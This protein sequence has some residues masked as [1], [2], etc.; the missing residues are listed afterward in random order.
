MR[1]VQAQSTCRV[2][3][4]LYIISSFSQ[5]GISFKHERSAVLGPDYQTTRR[6]REIRSSST[7]NQSKSTTN[8]T[9]NLPPPMILTHKETLHAIELPPLATFLTSLSIP[10]HFIKLNDILLRYRTPKSY[11]RMDVREISS[12]ELP[13][14]SPSPEPDAEVESTEENVERRKK[15]KVEK[16]EPVILDEGDTVEEYKA[17]RGTSIAVE[18]DTTKEVGDENVATRGVEGTIPNG[19]GSSTSQPIDTPLTSTVPDTRPRSPTPPTTVKP[20]SRT[21][22][23]P[24]THTLPPSGPTRR[25]RELRLDLRT[26]DAAALFALETWRRE[27]MRL[28]KLKMEHPD[29]IW[30]KDPTPTPTPE[31]EPSPEPVVGRRKA[32]RPR[33]GDRKSK[34]ESRTPAVDETEGVEVLDEDLEVE[35]EVDVEMGESAGEALR[36]GESEQAVEQE[37]VHDIEAFDNLVDGPGPSLAEAEST[38]TDPAPISAAATNAKTT[39]KEPT[40]PPS[41]DVIVVD[42]YNRHQDDSDF[43]PEP[44][45]EPVKRRG[46]GRKNATSPSGSAFQEVAAPTPMASSFQ[47]ARPP[48]PMGSSLF[49]TAESPRPMGSSSKAAKPPMPMGSSSFRT[50]KLPTPM[51]SSLFQAAEPSVPMRSSIFTQAPPP[52]ALGSSSRRPFV[53]SNQPNHDQVVS[54]I[55]PD[56]RFSL[57]PTRPTPPLPPAH[58]IPGSSNAPLVIPDSPKKKDRNGFVPF[59]REQMRIPT[60]SKAPAV[61][62]RGLH[63]HAPVVD[64][65][66]K[67]KGKEVMLDD[68]ELDRS[69]P[70]KVKAKGRTSKVHCAVSEDELEEE[71]LEDTY[72]EQRST[73]RVDD[74]DDDEWGDFKF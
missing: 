68:E 36:E 53:P 71:V 41:P 2:S 60:F 11:H 20:P 9:L 7:A 45:P 38:S 46:R 35:V 28:E 66:K 59:E 58:H 25:I 39:E 49:Q 8:M 64:A 37:V 33:K 44:S 54:R 50:T 14:S 31:P 74:D 19:E 32:G 16:G 1:N 65:G 3:C 30:Y 70:A 72:E 6:E 4:Q 12:S 42:G 51:V 5:V 43:S 34:S 69:R 62:K 63:W 17:R 15:R 48:M 61:P 67:R 23:P 40:P 27:L 55:S 47:A 73:E 13:L 57:S 10:E 18:Q 26:L 21:K 52:T 56:Q 22:S 29:S 24:A